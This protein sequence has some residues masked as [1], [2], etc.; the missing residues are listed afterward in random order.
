MSKLNLDPVKFSAGILV[1]FFIFVGISQ[2]DSDPFSIEVTNS[3]DAPQLIKCGE[4][5]VLHRTLCSSS[6]VKM[7]VKRSFFFLDGE[8]ESMP[9]NTDDGEYTSTPGVCEDVTFYINIPEFF[10]EG[11]YMY[12]ASVMYRVNHFKTIY[13]EVPPEYFEVYKPKGCR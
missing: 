8:G 12:R 6:A 3:G 2:L 5:I 1:I 4:P 9:I 11:L 13:K 10:N 7:S